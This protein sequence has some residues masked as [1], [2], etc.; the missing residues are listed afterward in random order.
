MD[1]LYL[2]GFVN[3][4]NAYFYLKEYD[5]AIKNYDQS[6]RLNPQNADYYVNR[7]ARIHVQGGQCN[8]SCRL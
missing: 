6:I 7:G 1:E 8:C 3:L 5:D 2:D 4:G